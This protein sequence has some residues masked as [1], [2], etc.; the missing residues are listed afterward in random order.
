MVEFILIFM[1]A[2]RIGDMGATFWLWLI[3]FAILKFI[4]F[5]VWA[6]TDK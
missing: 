4:R 6:L 3:V 2:L 1:L 5:V